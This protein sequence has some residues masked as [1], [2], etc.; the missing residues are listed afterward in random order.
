VRY[1]SLP[2]FL[3]CLTF[4]FSICSRPI[5]RSPP[6]GVAYGDPDDEYEDVWDQNEG[7]QIPEPSSIP[8]NCNSICSQLSQEEQQRRISELERSFPLLRFR[9]DESTLLRRRRCHACVE[10]T[11]RMKDQPNLSE[12][13]RTKMMKLPLDTNTGVLKTQP[14]LAQA[15]CTVVHGQRSGSAS[16]SILRPLT[17]HDNQYGVPVNAVIFNLILTDATDE[18]IAAAKSLEDPTAKVKAMPPKL[19][20]LVIALGG[21]GDQTSL[22]LLGRP[23]EFGPAQNTIYEPC[24]EHILDEGSL[25]LQTGLAVDYNQGRGSLLSFFTRKRPTEAEKLPLP[26]PAD[27]LEDSY[28]SKRDFL[29]PFQDHPSST[30][31]WLD[32]SSSISR[33]CEKSFWE[34]GA[35]NDVAVSRGCLDGSSKV[36]KFVL[37]DP[38]DG[39]SAYSRSDIKGSIAVLYRGNC[40]FVQKVHSMQELGAVGVVVVNRPGLG[41]DG[42]ALGAMGADGTDREIV[43]PSALLSKSDG[44]RLVRAVSLS[45]V[46]P[47][48]VLGVMTVEPLR[49]KRFSKPS[50]PEAEAILKASPEELE[51]K[52]REVEA[53]IAKEVKGPEVKGPEVKGPEVKV[54]FKVPRIEMLVPGS[55][56]PFVQA[57][58]IN[59]GVDL[60]SLLNMLVQDG[61]VSGLLTVLGQAQM[62]ARA[63][64]M[65]HLPPDKK[66][67]ENDNNKGNN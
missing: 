29:T 42:E 45:A 26:S 66:K 59:K 63:A 48:P 37:A 39:C 43:I 6:E 17:T 65:M 33:D 31:S 24:L 11:A 15:V 52:A 8:L 44:Q 38:I 1:I 20:P 13:E 55:S 47:R 51:L 53:A 50:S 40:S 22:L 30:C 28:M 5:L 16:C 67:K 3:Q 18:E 2:P 62:T 35:T 56:A 21:F 64:E 57:Q 61:K 49:V 54:E 23:A 10:V 34:E 60:N 41:L 58:F 7:S 14:V 4:L 27:F 32:T 9:S 19:R 46:G 36:G 25:S 12:E